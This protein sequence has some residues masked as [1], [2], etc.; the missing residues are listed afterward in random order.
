MKHSEPFPSFRFL[1]FTLSFSSLSL[2]F[3]LA[4]KQRTHKYDIP[5]VKTKYVIGTGGKE[6]NRQR[7][8]EDMVKR[9]KDWYLLN[10]RIPI[11]SPKGPVITTTSLAPAAAL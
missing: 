7:E 2:L 11:H 8:E 4:R 9:K 10:H 3:L 1:F 6:A 5:K